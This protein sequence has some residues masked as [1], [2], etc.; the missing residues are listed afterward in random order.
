MQRVPYDSC[1]IDHNFSQLS[2]Q[3]RE[4]IE[5]T[6]QNFE[7]IDNLLWGILDRIDKL[8]KRGDPNEDA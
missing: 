5:K 7:N 8:E 6:N 3:L 4:L 2:V 1:L